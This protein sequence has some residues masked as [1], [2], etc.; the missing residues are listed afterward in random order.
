LILSATQLKKTTGW[1]KKMVEFSGYT[2]ED[3]NKCINE[4]KSFA[5]EI[6]P[7]FISTLRYKFSKPEYMKVANYTF[8][9]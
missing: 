1:S 5:L 3:L 7:K 6:N 4:V 9:F 2:L 8:S